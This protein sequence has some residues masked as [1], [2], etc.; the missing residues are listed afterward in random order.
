LVLYPALE[1]L[2]KPDGFV[3]GLRDISRGHVNG[4]FVDLGCRASNAR[5]LGSSA[6]AS[7]PNS[8]PGALVVVDARALDRE[9]VHERLEHEL[10]LAEDIG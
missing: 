4:A 2:G 3:G 7:S 5:Q 9:G 6:D 1:T 8:S 10:V